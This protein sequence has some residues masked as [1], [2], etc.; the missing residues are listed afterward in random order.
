[1]TALTR[2]MRRDVLIAVVGLLMAL[3]ACRQ[4]HLA[5]N[6]VSLE[7]LQVGATPVTIFRPAGPTAPR[8]AVLISHGFAGSQQLML[9]FALSLARSGYLAVTFDYFGHG[10][11]PDA[12][13]GDITRVEGAT[14]MLVEQTRGI[15]DYVADLPDASGELALLG[16][17]MASDIVVRLARTDPRVK[18]TVAVSMFSTAVTPEAPANLLVIVGGWE[19]FLKAEALR[20][21]GLVT[22]SPAAGVTVGDPAQGGARR[23]VFADGVEHV[24][25]LYSAQAQRCLLYTSPSPRD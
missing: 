15:A 12:L 7:R 22:A 3:A 13:R 23:V 9:S 24:G 14:R 2:A 25:V 20:V 11:H 21:Q 4:L 10:R 5:A 19:G 1:M 6:G 17:S 18:A 16:H 8:P